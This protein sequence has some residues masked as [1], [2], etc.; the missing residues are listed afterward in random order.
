MANPARVLL[1]DNQPDFLEV[2]GFWLA[3]KGYDVRKA[4]SGQEALRCIETDA[5]DV[6]LLD[7][8]MPQMGG[9]ETLR[10]IRTI[11]KT[12]PV[13]LIAADIE[14]TAGERER[15][16]AGANALGI[17]GCFAKRN[18]FRQLGELLQAALHVR[19]ADDRVATPVRVLHVLQR[20][21]STLLPRR[22]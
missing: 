14:E 22:R 8:R 5:P 16:L 15:A 20:I 3:S 4:T 21:L 17:V 9:L 18:D 6:V 11:A 1:V 7:V 13:I 10:R 12:L 19:G 2:C